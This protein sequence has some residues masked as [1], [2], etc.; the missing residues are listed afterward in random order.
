M[1]HKMILLLIVLSLSWLWADE[2]DDKVRQLQKI[3]SQLESA[4]KKAKQ[5]SEKKKQT[6]TEIKRTSSLKKITEQNLNKLK[7]DERT[8]RD[9][10][11]S[12]QQRLVLAEERLGQLH[13]AQNGELNILMRV[14]RS[15]KKQNITHRDHRYLGLLIAQNRRSIDVLQGYK[16]A[17][18]TAQELHAQEAQKISKNVK[19]EDSKN[20]KLTTQIKTLT[21]QS[22]TLSKEE[23]ALQTQIA[24]LKKDAAALETLISRLMADTGKTPSTYQF[25]G[26]KIAWPVKGKIIRSYGQET[27]SYGTSVVSNGI[28]IALKEGTN[29]VAADDGEVIFSD[30]Y[31]GQGKLIIIDHKNGFFT[32]YAYNSDLLVAKGAKV[33]RGQ[34]IAK[35]GMTGSAEEP[36]LHFELRKDGKAINPIP[37]LE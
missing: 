7:T 36:S 17:L 19:T 28:D 11:Q 33:K 30:R 23:K 2:I 21:T 26:K 10:L 5:T 14:D 3:Q 6:E 29:V 18:S 9:S 31:G 34:T 1:R 15:F 32:L 16:A 13:Q 12:V 25:T 8:V 4:E 35:S 20:K 22:Q 27:K 37:Y 24:N